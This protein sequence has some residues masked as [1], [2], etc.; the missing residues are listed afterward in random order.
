M[1]KKMEKY[2]QQFLRKNVKKEKNTNT[3]SYVYIFMIKV[4]LFYNK[5]KF[6]RN[7]GK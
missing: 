1:L 3:G 4:Y 7:S 5:V 6:M 2:A